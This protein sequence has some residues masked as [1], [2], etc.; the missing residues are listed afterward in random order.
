LH[1]EFGD[2][3]T[4]QRVGDER[5]PLEVERV[6][7]TGERLG[8]TTDTERRG[9]LLASTVPGQLGDEHRE[10]ACERLRERKHVSTRDAEPMH[11]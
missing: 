11:E 4:P 5:R 3:L 8:E 7:A 2:D 9:R 1:G 10:P 6:Y